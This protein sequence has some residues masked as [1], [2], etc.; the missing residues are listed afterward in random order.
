MAILRQI[1]KVHQ[2]GLL[3]L[4][5]NESNV[6]CLNNYLRL[7]DLYNSKPHICGFANE[8][9]EGE[10]RPDVAAFGCYPL[11]VCCDEMRI[12]DNGKSLV[13]LP[14]PHNTY[15]NNP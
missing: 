12:W 5:V 2:Y 9:H 7:I 6:L 13:F 14:V 15:S 3:P 1:Q 10:L 8:F 11:W 4:D